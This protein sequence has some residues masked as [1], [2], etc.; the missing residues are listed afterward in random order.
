MGTA[1]YTVIVAEDEIL[2]LNHL[3]EKIRQYAPDFEVVGKAQTGDE[4]YQLVKQ[5]NPNLLI[6][7][8]RM[9]VMN[10]IELLEKVY[11]R[12]PL[13]KF[14]I[15]SGFS[16]FEYAQSAIR[17]KVSEYLLKPV[18]PEELILALRN[19]RKQYQIEQKAYEEIFNESMARNSPEQIAATL[20]D[21]L[22]KNY[23]VDTNLNLI[24]CNMHY[25][26]SYLTKIFQQQYQVSPLKFITQMRLA[27]AKHYL[28]HNPEI[29]VKQIGEMVGYQ[30][31]GYFSRLFKK[32]TGMSPLD[33]RNQPDN[34][35]A[36]P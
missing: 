4:A 29:S 26:P 32:N 36:E 11:N 1:K 5:H 35:A 24:A 10:G 34:T 8:I 14:I 31:Q 17:L 3:T 6:T 16:D 25:S 27:Q 13:T 2:L 15:I 18:D 22:V 21:Y 9:P 7:D 19:I 30:D 33:W 23:N 12:F 20:R 28:A